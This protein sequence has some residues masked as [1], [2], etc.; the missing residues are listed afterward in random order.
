MSQG[1]EEITSAA[2]KSEIINTMFL[3]LKLVSLRRINFL[4]VCVCFLYVCFSDRG[5]Q[6]NKFWKW[7]YQRNC[8]YTV[9]E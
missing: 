3:D 5:E 6:E 7:I 1:I 9:K 4:N 2:P 8:P